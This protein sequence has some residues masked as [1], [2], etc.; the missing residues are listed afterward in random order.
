[1]GIWRLP[2]R[3]ERERQANIMLAVTPESFVPDDH[4]PRRIK[5]LV[6]DAWRACRGASMRCTPAC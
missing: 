5:P 3:G 6:D 1:M 4:P 2:M